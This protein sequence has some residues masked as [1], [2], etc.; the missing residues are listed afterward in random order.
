MVIDY[1]QLARDAV[2]PGSPVLARI[3]QEFG[4]EFITPDGCLDRAVMANRIFN[5]PPARVRLESLIHPQV[6]ALATERET[7]AITENSNAIVIH[8]IPLLVEK[9]LAPQFDAVIVVNTQSPIREKRLIEA[10][11]LSPAEAR[12][13]IAAGASDAE[14]QVAGTH[15][16]NGNGTPENLEAQVSDLWQLL[17]NL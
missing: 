9:G 6:F 12:A 8:D 10:R 17:G 4:A 13:R 14:R 11:G 15:F 16:L 3:A 1:D 5:D 7:F 2:K